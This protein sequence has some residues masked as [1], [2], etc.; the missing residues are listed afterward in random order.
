MD[1]RVGRA[2]PLWESRRVVAEGSVVDLMDKNAEEGGGLVV[3]V[4]L[5]LGVDLD[6]ECG[7]DGG[8]QTSLHQVQ[9]GYTEASHETHEDQGGVQILVV[10]LHEFP[11][12]L[13]GL[14]AVVFVESSPVVL[15]S[16]LWILYLAA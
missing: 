5:E 4:R 2:C 8:E 6:D 14:L 1:Y 3:R 13:L 10:L 7:G 9:H 15:L 16:G 12:V 11:I